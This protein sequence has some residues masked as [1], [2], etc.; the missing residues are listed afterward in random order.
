MGL[1]LRLAFTVMCF[2]SA[3]FAWG[4]DGH[5]IIAQVASAHLSPSAQVGVNS[6]LE[7]KQL[8]DICTWADDI[9][10]DPD[11]SWSEPLHYVN[12]P[13]GATGFDSNRDC[14]DGRCVVTAIGKYVTTLE[15]KRAAVQERREAIKFVVHF[16]ADVH[17]PL[18]TGFRRDKGGNDIRVRFFHEESNLHHV[19]DE[20]IIKKT[21]K[22]WEEYGDALEKKILASDVAIWSSNMDP[23]AWA[24]ESFTLAT[25][26]AYPIPKDS[27][28]GQE[29]YR[30]NLLV[31]NQRLSMAGIRLAALLNRVFDSRPSTAPETATAS[32]PTD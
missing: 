2:A 3:C 17:Q 26:N 31:I 13:P 29:Y 11:Y 18:H 28:L 12:V 20:L 27:Q 9:R 1:C 19:W 4:G 24:S 21:G 14:S 10:S 30:K 22:K 23:A 32:A 25:T 6:L 8:P 15:D 5:K 16:V 7:G